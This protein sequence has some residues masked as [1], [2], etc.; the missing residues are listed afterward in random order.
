MDAD[1]RYAISPRVTSTGRVDA[2]S[3]CQAAQRLATRHFSDNAFRDTGH[4]R[5]K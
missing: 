1:H 5:A 4:G 2:N 3:I